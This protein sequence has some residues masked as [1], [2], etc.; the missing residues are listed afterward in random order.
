MPF[1]TWPHVVWHI[2]RAAPLLQHV[3]TRLAGLRV[4]TR[5][6]LERTQI[7]PQPA[8]AASASVTPLTHIVVAMVQMNNTCEI[9]QLDVAAAASALL[10]FGAD[11]NACVEITHDVA[12]N[13]DPVL[14]PYAGPAYHM[15]A[16][17]ILATQVRDMMQGGVST[18]PRALAMLKTLLERGADLGVRNGAGQTVR[19]MRVTREAAPLIA[20]QN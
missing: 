15:P 14:T 3:I 6:A 17:M 4:I 7:A 1:V 5:Q 11:V 2:T 9:M 8:D 16:A 19:E 10:D 13:G 12:P 20:E 18:Q